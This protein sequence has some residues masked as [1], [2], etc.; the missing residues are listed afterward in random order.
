M[1][2]RLSRR[3]IAVSVLAAAVVGAVV[4]LAVTGNGEPA[5]ALRL[6]TGD[7]W[8]EN[9]GAGTVSHV[10]GFTGGTDAQAA[11]GKPGDPFEV[12]QRPSGAY[13]L[14]LKTGR[15]SRLDDATL[16]VT[17]AAA[18]GRSAAALQIVTGANATWVLDHSSGILQ[19]LD[20]TTLA[21]VGPQI[22]LGG[23]TG[24]AIVDASGSVWAPVPFAAVVAQVGLAGAVTRHPF[25]H[26]GDQVQVADTTGGVWGLDPETATAAS[27]SGPGVPDVA[28]PALREPPLVAAS[29]SSPDLVV[30]AGTEVLNIDTA[31]PSLSSLVVPAAA[32]TTQV[33]VASGRAYL[34]DA[35]AGQ[36]E[37]INLAPMG[38]LA[39]VPVPR[40][41]N[42]LVTKDQLVFVNGTNTPQALV[43]GPSGSV[44]SIT[45]YS[46]APPTQPAG[47]TG[48]H[49]G[50]PGG[51]SRL[52]PTPAIPVSSPSA[53]VGAAPGGSAP[54]SPP[55]SL[56]APP[57]PPTTTVAPNTPPTTPA[58]PPS[59][60]PTVPG[61]PTVTVTAGS[62]LI[63]VTWSPPAFDGGSPVLRYQL[64]GSPTSA[65]TSVPASTTTV[66]LTG[67]TNGT[68]ECVQVQAVNRV[69]GGPLSP[70]GQSCATPQKNSPGQVSGITA[71]ESAA[72]QIT[73]SWRQPSLGP[74]NS[75]IRSYTVQGGPRP[76]PA[77]STSTTVTGLANATTYTFTVMA[78]NA[79][80]VS[81]PASAPVRSTTWSPPGAVA[82]LA[83]TGGDGALSIKWGAPSVPSGSPQVTGYEVSIGGQRQSTTLTSVSKS[84]PAWTNEKVTVYAV[85]SVGDGPTSSGSGMAWA[86]SPTHLCYDSLNGDRAIE[87]DCS[88]TGGAWTDEGTNTGVTWI[89]YPD[90]AGGHPAVTN[91]Y[92]CTTYVVNA[93]GLAGTQGVSGD[94]YA[95]VS[96]PSTGAC[97]TALPDYQKSPPDIPHPIASV[98]NTA[99]SSSSQH[100]CEYEGKSTGANGTFTAFELSPCG[101]TPNNLS[102]TSVKFSFYT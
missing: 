40:G 2:R 39:S 71:R 76:I 62:G 6:L 67:L 15:L 34:L 32:Q 3:R 44:T 18:E 42:Q 79:A 26:R 46:P 68:R 21:P 56:S 57:S 55:A 91:A 84:V 25:G 92:L 70:A 31:Q 58:P 38:V 77:Q 63:T 72:R 4:A 88:N 64:T 54:P 53:P 95:K 27:L 101:Q 75:P 10:S 43:V 7:V 11:V 9:S 86:R 78:T 83:V 36:L 97:T 82:Q 52:A 81:G 87:N 12:V 16:S 47:S 96:T 23:P 48:S 94:V 5:S 30:V 14:D 98:S 100:I 22:P 59:S 37:T 65:S 60:P 35:A 29:A 45:K 69:G 89:P 61:A 74:Y 24:T 93:P 50:G 17:A 102:S 20:S 66:S 73:L 85:S 51:P 90:Q 13:V 33:A 19:R 49:A 1:A 80:G 8:L 41:A 99:L 28:L